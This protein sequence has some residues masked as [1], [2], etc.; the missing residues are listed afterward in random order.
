MGTLVRRLSRLD[1]Y[2]PPQNTGIDLSRIPAIPSSRIRI[3][4]P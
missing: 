1:Y 3:A 4:L 2:I